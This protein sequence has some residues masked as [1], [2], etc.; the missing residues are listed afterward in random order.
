MNKNKVEEV[1][2]NK[3]GEIFV[4]FHTQLGVEY[5]VDSSE[6]SLETD[7]SQKELSQLISQL[8]GA[9]DK[10]GRRFEFIINKEFLRGALKEHLLKHNLG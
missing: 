5:K 3:I 2:K 6:M 1:S 7:L 4:S 9:E 8:L 10:K